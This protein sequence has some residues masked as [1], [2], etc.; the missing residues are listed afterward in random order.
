M[1]WF[2]T[3]ALFVIVR[4]TIFWF[5]SN[6]TSSRDTQPGSSV[7]SSCNGTADGL[8]HSADPTKLLE[9]TANTEVFGLI[10]LLYGLLLD[11]SSR[12]SQNLVTAAPNIVTTVGESRPVV[13]ASRLHDA[14]KSQFP[15]VDITS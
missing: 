7:S 12:P 13:G 3:G 14:S 8:N 11:P 15:S 10:P 9:T 6:S 2:N 4:F 1:V 5:S